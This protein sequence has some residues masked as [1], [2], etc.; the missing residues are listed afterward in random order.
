VE[1]LDVLAGSVEFGDT[2]LVAVAGF[3]VAKRNSLRLSQRKDRLDRITH[4]L[5]DF[6][7]LLFATASQPVPPGPYFGACSR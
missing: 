6:Y 2:R 1:D 7:G 3:L 5:S 4:Q